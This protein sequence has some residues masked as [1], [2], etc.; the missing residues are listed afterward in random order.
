[1]NSR[2]SLGLVEVKEQ[3]VRDLG[4]LFG[5]RGP[6]AFAEPEAR[7]R[8]LALGRPVRVSRG[9]QV[10]AA[11]DGPGGLY[12]VISGGIGAEVVTAQLGPRLGHVY[13]SGGWFGEGPSMSGGRRKLGQR[14][15]EDSELLLVPLGALQALHREDVG[16]S[17]LLGVI[18]EISSNI[19]ACSAREL[20][21]P[22]APRRIAAV[23]L[24][25]TAALDKVS[26]SDPRGFL[27]TQHD[28]GE[29]AN[30]SRHHV[31]RVL[32]LFAREGWIATSYNHIRLLDVPALATFAYSDD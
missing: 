8:F 7:A 18:A 32:G 2:S 29:M 16:I 13:R 23:L 27:V 28:L 4:Q 25:V 5:S 30:A 19:A 24:R 11:G 20:L 31:N 9:T 15:L 3:S 17:R 1:M 26:P 22:D 14:A 10:F 21:I 12:G 6:L